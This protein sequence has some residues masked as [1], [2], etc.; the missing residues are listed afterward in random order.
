MEQEMMNPITKQDIL[1]EYMKRME[2]HLT[3]PL[4]FEDRSDI[5]DYQRE[6][7]G[8]FTMMKTIIEDV[9]R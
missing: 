7:Y 5:Y 1:K 4:E 6:T 8:Y 2:N 9:Y 3:K